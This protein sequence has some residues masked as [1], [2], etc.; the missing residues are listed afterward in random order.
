[1]TVYLYGVYVVYPSQIFCPTF[2]F[3]S[4]VSIG[5]GEGVGK[6]SSS[7]FYSVP[8]ISNITEV[9]VGYHMPNPFTFSINKK[10][11]RLIGHSWPLEISQYDLK[12]KIAMNKFIWNSASIICNPFVFLANIWKNVCL[13][14]LWHAAG[15]LQWFPLQCFVVFVGFFRF[16]SLIYWFDICALNWFSIRTLDIFFFFPI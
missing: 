16:L 5:G 3:T 14:W 2:K 13:L 7:F 6:K 15:S 8:M 1:M 12:K 11:F 4:S 9:G 10:S